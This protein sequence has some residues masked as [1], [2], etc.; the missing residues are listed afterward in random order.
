[1]VRFIQCT[2]LNDHAE[3]SDL[4][5]LNKVIRLIRVLFVVDCS[6]S[7]DLECIATRCMTNVAGLVQR[8][9]GICAQI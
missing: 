9:F 4:L 7:R 3:L 1:M 5:N 6:G 2:D 8:G